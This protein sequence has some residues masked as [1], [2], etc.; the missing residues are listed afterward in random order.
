M[1]AGLALGRGFSLPF[2]GPPGE[3]TLKAETS[4][5]LEAT[6]EE[7]FGIPAAAETTMITETT[8]TSGTPTGTT[9]TGPASSTAATGA[10]TSSSGK[11]AILKGTGISIQV[12]SGWVVEESD[13]DDVLEIR[14]RGSGVLSGHEEVVAYLLLQ[15]ADLLSGENVGEFAERLVEE[16]L[17]STTSDQDIALENDEV[18]ENFHGVTVFAIDIV[19]RGG[20]M[21]YHMRNFYWVKGGQGYMMTFYATAWTFKD[22]E[23]TFNRMLESM[24]WEGT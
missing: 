18:I 20:F 9:P 7:M 10:S 4:G 15:K 23:P 14:W 8:S 2:I 22:R 5:E 16:F 11:R 1:C 21:P 6:D 13:F 24:R 17:D 12:P 3:I 19:A